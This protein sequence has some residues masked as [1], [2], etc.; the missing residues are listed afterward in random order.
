MSFSYPESNKQ[1]FDR[2]NLKVRKKALFTEFMEKVDK[3][4]SNPVQKL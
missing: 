2:L 1:V 4:K 3:G